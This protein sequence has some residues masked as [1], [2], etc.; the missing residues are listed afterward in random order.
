MRL[1]CPEKCV[2]DTQ[3][4]AGH[5]AW[6]ASVRPGFS[7]GIPSFK[8]RRIRQVHLFRSSLWQLPRVGGRRLGV[9]EETTQVAS[10]DG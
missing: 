8:R 9:G 3:P 7:L 1:G 2:G 4:R 6:Q 10:K 5:M